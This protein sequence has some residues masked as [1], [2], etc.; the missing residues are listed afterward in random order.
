MSPL[1]TLFVYMIVSMLFDLFACGIPALSSSSILFQSHLV[2]YLFAVAPPLHRHLML[3]VSQSPFVFFYP[4][5]FIF[6]H[7]PEARRSSMQLYTV[8]PMVFLHSTTIGAVVL[9][10]SLRSYC[11]HF[12]SIWCFV[13]LFGVDL[14]CSF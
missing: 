14:S 12:C 1:I 13:P 3:H 4:Q 6:L 8:A 5:C 10:V 2:C 11:I 7:S 9:V